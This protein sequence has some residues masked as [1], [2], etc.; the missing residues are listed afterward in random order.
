MGGVGRS[1]PGFLTKSAA[2]VGESTGKKPIGGSRNRPLCY[3]EKAPK[4]GSR[5]G[6]GGGGMGGP[7]SFIRTCYLWQSPR[8]V[9]CRKSRTHL[10]VRT[11]MELPGRKRTRGTFRRPS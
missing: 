3:S 4:Y 8:R 7:K 6:G 5:K 1:G 11:K 10:F 2:T 9:F